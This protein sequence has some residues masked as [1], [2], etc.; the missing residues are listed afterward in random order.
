MIPADE[1]TNPLEDEEEEEETRPGECVDTKF[2]EFNERD[3]LLIRGPFPIRSTDW[4]A[5]L[6]V[7]ALIWLYKQR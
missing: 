5:A 1:G 4:A 2:R 7:I 6:K 3:I